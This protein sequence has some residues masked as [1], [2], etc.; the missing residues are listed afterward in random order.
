[1]DG[2]TSGG[3]PILD[4]RVSYDQSTDNF[5]VFRTGEVSSKSFIATGLETGRTY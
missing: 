2:T 4:Y 3:V 1:M 5:V